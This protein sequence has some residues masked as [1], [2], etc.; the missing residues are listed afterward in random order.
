MDG[1]VDRSAAKRP[2]RR[3]ILRHRSMAFT[4]MDERLV[5]RVKR[6]T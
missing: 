6:D 2:S 3:S 5:I 1:N 4:A